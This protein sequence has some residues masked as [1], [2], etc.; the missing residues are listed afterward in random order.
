MLCRIC[1]A[2]RNIPFNQKQRN[3]AH[4]VITDFKIFESMSMDLNVMPSSHRGYNYL[5]VMRSN[6]SRYIITEALK[7]RQAKEVVE[8]IFQ[9]LICA[10]G[11]NIKKIYVL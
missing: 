11:T 5:L 6:N 10:H 8:A 3:W 9:N 4:T 1:S 7:T 2:R